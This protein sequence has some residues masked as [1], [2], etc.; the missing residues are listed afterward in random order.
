[1]SIGRDSTPWSCATTWSDHSSERPQDG[2][3]ASPNKTVEK[4][5]FV[6]VRL[7]ADVFELGRSR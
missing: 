3:S 5:N 2:A 1:M 6:L 7:K 4:Q